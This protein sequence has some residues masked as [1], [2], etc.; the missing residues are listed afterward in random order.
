MMADDNPCCIICKEN[1]CKSDKG[2]E[3]TILCEACWLKI[4]KD[5][6]ISRS[7]WEAFMEALFDEVHREK[8]SSRRFSVRPYLPVITIK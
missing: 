4:T 6:G 2:S 5:S 3:K 8:Y 7:R 1:F